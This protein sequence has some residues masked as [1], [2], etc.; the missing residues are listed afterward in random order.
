MVSSKT[1][2]HSVTSDVI[3]K[4]HLTL[5]NY[6]SGEEVLEFLKSTEAVFMEEVNRF[7]QTEIE[8]MKASLTENQALYIG[9][10]I[11]ASYIAGFLIA[12]EANNQMFKTHFD[13]KAPASPHLDGKDIEKLID[14]GIEG[15]KSYRE[16]AKVIEGILRGKS[17]V[18]KKPKEKIK[19]RGKHLDLGSLE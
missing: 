8:R 17:K 9:S 1:P 11:G 4:I 10:I 12:R 6:K 7:I 3:R 5:A 14:K 2:E 15:G 13:F 19:K 16:I 18:E